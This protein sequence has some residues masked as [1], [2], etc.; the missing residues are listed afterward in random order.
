MLI[1]ELIIISVRYTAQ[2]NLQKGVRECTMFGQLLGMGRAPEAGR[3][4]EVIGTV[5]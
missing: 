4:R 3:G 2:N 5:R 1:N